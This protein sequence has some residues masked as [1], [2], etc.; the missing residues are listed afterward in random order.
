MQQT[1]LGYGSALLATLIWSG[2]FVVARALADLIPPWQCN[3]WRWLV[4]LLVLLP[5]AGPH[6]RQDWPGIRKHWGYLSLM[7][8]LGVTLMN[9]LIYKAGQSTESL[10][11]AL[12]VPT[13]PIVILVFS[14]ILYGEPITPRRLAGV[15]VVLAGVLILVSRGEWQRLAGLKINS[16]DFW[17]LGCAFCFGLYSLFMRR[18]PRQISPLSFNAATFSLGLLCALPFTVAEACLLP[19]PRLSPTLITGVLYAGIGCSFAAFWFWTLAVDRIGPVQAGIVYYS[20]PVFAAVASVLVLH[21]TIAP[22]QVLGGLLV[23]GG[24]LVATLVVPRQRGR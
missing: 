11:M 3:F 14:R 24:I 20:L 22:P 19:L 9:T 6:L 18:R 21:E 15:L 5:F 10:N 7:G 16:G 23:I 12:L 13:A 4:A 1:A 8:I 2:N 17:A